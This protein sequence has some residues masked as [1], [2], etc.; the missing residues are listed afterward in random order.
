MLRQTKWWRR[1]GRKPRTVSASASFR[2]LSQLLRVRS[3][4]LLG[5]VCLSVAT[6][7]QSPRAILAVDT[8]GNPQMIAVALTVAWLFALR[9]RLNQPDRV[10][11]RTL[12]LGLWFLALAYAWLGL[13][14]QISHF[15]LLSD[16]AWANVLDAVERLAWP[17]FAVLA[18]LV[19][20][21]PLKN[22]LARIENLEGPGTKVGFAAAAQNTRED[23]EAL[24]FDTD[25]SASES[26]SFTPEPAN[27]AQE[28]RKPTEPPRHEQ[29][30]RKQ[31][32]VLELQ[33]RDLEGNH[34]DQPRSRQRDAIFT[35]IVEAWVALE[36]DAR[37]AIDLLQSA[38]R[39]D[40]ATLKGRPVLRLP[41][42]R[43]FEVLVQLEALP[44]E[45][46]SVA[47]RTQ[48]LRNRLMHE[49][50]GHFDLESFRDL[51]ATIENLRTALNSGLRDVLAQ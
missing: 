38:G 17:L 35:D 9:T 25:K 49:G 12:E 51:L 28:P 13:P 37:G 21:D 11:G 2:H 30:T 50:T 43:V 39:Y 5:L 36:K 42:T 14:R 16:D 44:P 24:V 20:R 45:V 23:S 4:V 15:A 19:L 1:S 40:G 29:D 46:I 34:Y 26:D 31:P 33:I 6:L 7:W 18:L 32:P 48:H 10:S 3:A 47:R 27:D 41:V 8:A 22:L